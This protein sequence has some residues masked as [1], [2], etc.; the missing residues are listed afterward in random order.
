MSL[1]NRVGA[2]NREAERLFL[3]GRLAMA[4][5][6]GRANRLNPVLGAAGSARLTI[7][8][9]GKTY[10]DLMEALRRSLDSVSIEKK[11][12]VKAKI[13]KVEK[14]AA[15]PAAKAKKRKTA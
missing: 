8:V 9:P 6:Y 10:L 1:P 13:E 11:K 7:V 5:A 12:P 14:V 15:A 3:K 2:R 4:R